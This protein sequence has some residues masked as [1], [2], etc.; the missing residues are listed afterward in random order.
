MDLTQK[1]QVHPITRRAPFCV[2][3]ISNILEKFEK[4]WLRNMKK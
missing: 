4:K 1:P 3:I 2:E